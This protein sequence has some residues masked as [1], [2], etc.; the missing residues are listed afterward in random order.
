MDNKDYNWFIEADLCEYRGEYVIIS[1]Q[2]VVLHGH[3]LK[4]MVAQ[5]KEKYPAEVPKI[6][7]IPEEATLILGCRA[8]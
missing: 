4:R 5:F 1:K 2:K 3:D 7:W 8:W 6:A